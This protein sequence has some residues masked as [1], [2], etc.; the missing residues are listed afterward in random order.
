MLL[1][2]PPSWKGT[3]DMKNS[4]S[5]AACDCSSQF[6]YLASCN[7]RRCKRQPPHELSSVSKRQPIIG[8]VASLNNSHEHGRGSFFLDSPTILMLK[9]RFFFHPVRLNLVTHMY[10]SRGLTSAIGAYLF[11]STLSFRPLFYLVLSRR[12]PGL[13]HHFNFYQLIMI[14]LAI[15][16]CS[17]RFLAMDAPY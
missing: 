11:L 2:N 13:C 4:P 5:P 16:F 14:L 17:F 9:P 15:M 1:V 10:A 3:F 12:S 6:T 8:L 7:S